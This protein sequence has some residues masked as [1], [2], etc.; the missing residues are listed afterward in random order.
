MIKP[1]KLFDRILQGHLENVSFEDFL[2]LAKA[3]DF[4]LKRI[5]GS[6]HILYHAKIDVTIPIQPIGKNQ[7]K[8]Y[9]IKQLLEKIKTFKLMMTE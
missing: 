6:H 4:R 7:A 1:H 9:Q 3:F 8:P 5:T 2:K